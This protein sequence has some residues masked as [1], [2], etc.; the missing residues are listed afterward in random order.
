MFTGQGGEKEPAKENT[1][2]TGE[3]IENKLMVMK[4]DNW[5]KIN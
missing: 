4:E 3:D 5:G 1:E 2:Q